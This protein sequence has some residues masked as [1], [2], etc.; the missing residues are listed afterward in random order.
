MDDNTLEVL[1]EIR[2]MYENKKEFNEQC[3]VFHSATRGLNYPL[4]SS[5]GNKYMKALADYNHLPHIKFHG[6]RHGTTSRKRTHK[7]DKF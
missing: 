3:Y 6:L 2:S 7:I 4:S 1:L 5:T